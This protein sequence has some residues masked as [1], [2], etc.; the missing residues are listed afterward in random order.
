[1]TAHDYKYLN[2]YRCPDHPKIVT[3]CIDDKDGGFRVFGGK[4]C[5]GQYRERIWGWA[6]TDT[7]IDELVEE[8][9]NARVTP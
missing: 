2:I 7:R 4:C 5:V 8:L 6:L 3:L 9:N 1:M